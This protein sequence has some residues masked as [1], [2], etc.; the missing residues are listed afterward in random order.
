MPRTCNSLSHRD[1]GRVAAA[2]I[3]VI[4]LTL[5]TV[6]CSSNTSSNG[7]KSSGA[8]TTTAAEQTSIG[9][10]TVVVRGRSSVSG[11]VAV[12][13]DDNYFKP[14]I[15]TAP[16]GSTITLDLESEGKALHN[17]TESADAINHDLEPD[18]K[19]AATVHVPASGQIIFFC[20]YH[21][22]EAGMVGAVNAA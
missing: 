6:G 15:L 19:F 16:A 22:D 10:Q 9:G 2:A 14:N 11:H 3:F 12:E 4:V 1:R 13:V 7:K 21:K 17:I 20:K 8:S 5:F 18:A